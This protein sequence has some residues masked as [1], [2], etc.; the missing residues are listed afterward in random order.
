MLVA[1][2]KTSREIAEQLVISERTAEVHVGNILAKLGFT[3]RTQ[4]AVWAV[5]H[6]LA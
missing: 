2:G 4:I 6:G 5:E 1:H 3:T